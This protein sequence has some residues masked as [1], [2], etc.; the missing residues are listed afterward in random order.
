M[1]IAQQ[2]GTVL[3]PQVSLPPSW[4][5]QLLLTVVA[6][7]LVFGPLSLRDATPHGDSDSHT[8]T[9]T[10]VAAEC[11]RG[12]LSSDAAESQGAAPATTPHS[13]CVIHCSLA[14]LLFP[15]LLLGAPL[16]ATRLVCF[17]SPAC[18]RL[19]APPLSPPP[20]SAH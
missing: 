12:L 4:L 17:L 9:P 5:G 20:Q 1:L 18:K 14:S 2:R 16:L 8:A 10:T 6:V 13:H 11:L 15:L 7:T 19:A 3:R